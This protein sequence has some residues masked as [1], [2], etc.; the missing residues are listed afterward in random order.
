MKKILVI[1]GPN[2]NMLG[3]REPEIYGHESYDD[4]VNYV[5]GYAKG[6][7]EVDF[8]QSNHEGCLI[9]K[10]QSARGVYDGI[11]L[12]AGGYTHTSVAIHDAVLVACVPTV[13][14]HISNIREREKFRHFSYMSAVCVATIMGKGFAGYTEALDLLLKRKEV[15]EEVINPDDGYHYFFGYYDLIAKRDGKHLAHRVDFFDRL[16]TAEDVCTLGYLKDKEFFPFA[17]TTAWNF[18]QGALLQWHPTERDSVIYNVNENGFKTVVHNLKTGQKTYTDRACATVS[19]CGGYGLAIDF[20]SVFEFRPGYGYVDCPV[21]EDGV[22]LVDFKTGESKNIIPQSALY[23]MGFDSSQRLLVNHINFSPDSKKFVML[24]RNFYKK[25]EMWKTSLVTGFTDGGY[26]VLLENTVVSHYY[27]VNDDELVIYCKVKGDKCGLYRLNAITGEYEE[28]PI[29]YTGDIH[30]IES[31]DGEY[32]I[33]DA[34]VPRGGHTRKIYGYS[35][36]TGN[37]A[38]VFEDK[39]KRDSSDIRCDLHNRFIDDGKYIS[40]D[41]IHRGKRDIVVIPADV[42]DF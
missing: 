31:P 4:L 20:G 7:A 19:R 27:W 10:I 1:N 5:S 33:G 25:G 29:E 40:F 6:K 26:K 12:N 21:T 17:T 16:P 24:V 41:S 11:I 9:D 14:V 30:C 39:S 34:Y 18:Q 2:L 8:Y 23:D 3:L 13:E 42:L 35:K 36:K 37:T 28:Y 22:Y 32:I 15:E 38:V